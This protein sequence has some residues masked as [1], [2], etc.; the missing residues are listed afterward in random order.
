MYSMTVFKSPRWWEKEQRYVYDNKTHRRLDFDSWERLEKFFYKLSERELNGKQEAELI[1]PAVFK[2]DSPRRNVNVLAWA[3]WCAVDVDDAEIEGDVNAFVSQLA[4]F[5]R[6]VCY[7]TASSKISKPKFRLIFELDRHLQQS[8]IKHFWFALQSHLDDRGDKQ[9]KDLCRM[10]YVPAQYSES[11]NFI[12]SGGT[13]PVSVDYLLARYPYVDDKKA[14][15][16]LDRLPDAWKE[17]IIE[18]RKSALDDTAYK[19]SS[20]K[21]CPFVNKKLI[22]EW[23]AIANVDGTGR[24]RMIYKIMVAI[25]MNAVKKSYPLTAFELVELIRQLDADTSNKYQSRALEIEANNA[26]EYAYK[27]GL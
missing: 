1:T 25:S 2:A 12:F 13:D 17:Q 8:E 23:N 3:G 20:Y 24:Y 18:H 27:Y 9:C 22:D 4:G 15:S 7:S 10:Y 11:Y 19:W 6:Y 16:F 21:D 5:W 14:Q 26:L